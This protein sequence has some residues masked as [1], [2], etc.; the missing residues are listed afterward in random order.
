MSRLADYTQTVIFPSTP[1]A[2][3]SGKLTLLAGAGVL[4]TSVVRVT[5]S[6]ARGSGTRGKGC[7]VYVRCMVGARGMGPG[8]PPC[9]VFTTVAPLYS[10]VLHC[11]STVPTVLHCGYCTG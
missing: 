6:G 1:L 5:G 8:C 3:I 10:T 2:L 4:V 9:T 11:G 7:G